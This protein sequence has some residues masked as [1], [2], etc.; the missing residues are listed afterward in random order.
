MKNLF[1][2]LICVFLF[3]ACGGGVDSNKV[4]EIEQMIAA[5]DYESAQSISDGIVDNN[6]L[7][8]IQVYD[9]CKLSI[10]YAKLSDVQQQEDN[11][12]KAAKCFKAATEMNAD[13][14]AAFI[15]ELPLEDVQYAMLLRNL[16]GSI[17]MPVDIEAEEPIEAEVGSESSTSEAEESPA[18]E[19]KEPQ[20]DKKAKTTKKESKPK[21][22][23]E[24]SKQKTKKAS[25]KT[26]K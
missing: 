24:K 22:S 19:P 26:D 3:T 18:E 21:T 8:A 11:M 6:D 16:T 14:V 7:K 17:G 9:L 13:S 2:I 4:A 23:K 10:C 12:A 5:K 25:K 20:K 1:L 15:T